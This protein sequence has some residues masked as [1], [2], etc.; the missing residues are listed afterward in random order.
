MV[1]N[2]RS[3]IRRKIQYKFILAIYIYMRV[4]RKHIDDEYHINVNM[5][6]YILKLKNM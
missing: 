6:N 2:L 3:Q 5:H 4:V 1:N